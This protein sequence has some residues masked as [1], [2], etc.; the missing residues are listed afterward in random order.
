MANEKHLEILKQGVDTW[1]RWREENPDVKPDLYKASLSEVNLSK[2]N[3][4]EANLREANLVWA[5]LTKANLYL[6][7]LTGADLLWAKLISANLRYTELNW[8]NFAKANLSDAKIENANLS[9]A[10]LVE[11]DLEDAT[12]ANCRVY[13]IAA[14]RL[15]LEGA[16]LSDLIITP[17]DEPTIMVDNLEV[18]QFLYMI[19]YNER[20]SGVINTITTKVVLILGRFTAERKAVLDAIRD[21]LRERNYVPILFDFDKPAS[22]DLTETVLI[23]AHMARFIIADI[24]EPR[25]IPLELQAI[26]PQLAVP[27]QPLLLEDSS[28]EFGMFQDLKKKYPWVLPIYQYEGL[29]TLLASLSE[30][31]IAPAEA[32][33]RELEQR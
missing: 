2:A 16:T 5:D 4:R 8:V 33:A 29:D 30:T 23:L 22:R 14:W 17:H 13:G 20:I 26:V 27:V 32:K 18:A 10:C 12:L 7:A 19:L 11:T 28:G 21:E 31:V 1:N 25:S 6:A 9:N 15:G 3:L 24:T